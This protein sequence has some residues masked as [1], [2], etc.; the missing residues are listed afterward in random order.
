MTVHLSVEVTVAPERAQEFS[1]VTPRLVAESVQHLLDRWFKGAEFK[2][3]AV[4]WVGAV[5]GKP[6]TCPSDGPPWHEPPCEALG[7][8]EAKPYPFLPPCPHPERN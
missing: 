7:M 4:S 2:V 3:E 6:C 1:K 5:N 8:A